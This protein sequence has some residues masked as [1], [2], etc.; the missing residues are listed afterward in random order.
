[1]IFSSPEPMAQVSF[2]DQ[3]LSVVS[4]C[5]RRHWRYR[6]LF[7]FSSYFPEPMGQFQPNLAQSIFWWRGFF[8]QNLYKIKKLYKG[9]F[10]YIITCVIRLC[11]IAFICLVFIFIFFFNLS[12]QI[13][14]DVWNLDSFVYSFSSDCW[15][16]LEANH[17][18]K[19]I[20]WY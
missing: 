16:S 4:R 3:N 15:G 2:S 19:G 1:M 11:E 6:K 5:H 12:F 18:N 20:V 14:W 7:T 17:K 13:N 10:F 8:K 9:I